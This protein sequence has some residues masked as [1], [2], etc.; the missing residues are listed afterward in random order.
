MNAIR[1]WRARLIAAADRGAS[2]RLSVRETRELAGLLR[3]LDWRTGLSRNG[4]VR[5]PGQERKAH[6]GTEARTRGSQ[7]NIG[8]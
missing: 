6:G 3:M 7:R 1:P 2:V 8:R 4:S 5:V